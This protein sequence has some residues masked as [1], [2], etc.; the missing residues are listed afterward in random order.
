MTGGV[1]I[2]ESETEVPAG[3]KRPNNPVPIPSNSPPPISATEFTNG[4]KNIIVN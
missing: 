2:I 3:I 1:R 4:S